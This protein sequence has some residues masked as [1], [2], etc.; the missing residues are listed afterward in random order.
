[1]ANRRHGGASLRFDNLFAGAVRSRKKEIDRGSLITV[2]AFFFPP[3]IFP[4]IAQL[5][6]QAFLYIRG[7]RLSRSFFNFY[8]NRLANLVG[9]AL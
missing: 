5:M 4:F 8:V 9:S 7:G 1:V 3:R 6:A 2:L